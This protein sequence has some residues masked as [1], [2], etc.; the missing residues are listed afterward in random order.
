VIRDRHAKFVQF[1]GDLPSLFFDLDDDPGELVDRA[2]DP[3]TAARQL[4]YARRLLRLRM[5]HTD[6]R[7]ANRRAVSPG[8]VHRADPPRPAVASAPA[9][10]PASAGPA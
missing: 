2:G 8:P 9:S 1:G 3:S 4:D 7:L 6:P 10:A 5:S